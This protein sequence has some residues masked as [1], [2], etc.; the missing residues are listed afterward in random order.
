MLAMIMRAV[1]P[2]NMPK[3]TPSLCRPLQR[4]EGQN[5]VR[6]PK[7]EPLV[8]EVLGHQ[9]DSQS[10]A[11]DHGEQ[12]PFEYPAWLREES[13]ETGLH[14]SGTSQSSALPGACSRYTGW[15]RALRAGVPRRW[16]CGS[17][18]TARRCLLQACGEPGLSGASVARALSSSERS[19]SPPSVTVADS[20]M[21]WSL[22]LSPEE[23]STDLER[24]ALSP[25]ISFCTRAFSSNIVLESLNRQ[26]RHSS[27]STAATLMQ[28]F[29]Q[30]PLRLRP[31]LEKATTLS[32]LAWPLRPL[33]W[34]RASAQPPGKCS[35][36]LPVGSIVLRRSADRHL[37]PVT[38]DTP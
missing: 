24:S 21:C 25:A 23:S 12:R 16:S 17:Y 34:S 15:N 7:H 2:P 28:C 32:R 4:K 36:H 31:A 20:A 27:P 13:L 33:T 38:I 9:V 3:A 6:L 8:G 14:L 11:C 19:I 5:L 26:A 35:L 18:H 29:V 22:G 10:E 1:L 37:D 30:S